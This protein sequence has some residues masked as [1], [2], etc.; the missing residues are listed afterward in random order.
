MYCR[1]RPQ[2]RSDLGWISGVAFLGTLTRSARPVQG[3]T[4]V[5]CCSMPPASSPHGLAAPGLGRLTTAIPACSCLQLAVATNSLRRGLPPPIQCP[6]L[7]HQV[8]RLRRAAKR[9]WDLTARAAEQI[10]QP[11]RQ[12]ILTTLV[13]I[14]GVRLSVNERQ[15]ARMTNRVR[16]KTQ[17]ALW[18][19]RSEEHT[20]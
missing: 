18:F 4:C 12:W 5:R 11:C 13:S 7:A 3:F 8:P 10:G 6:C 19:K 1:S 20:S 9:L 15:S 17:E 2:Y 16:R 14:E